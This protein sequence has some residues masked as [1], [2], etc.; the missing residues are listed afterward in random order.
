MFFDYKLECYLGLKLCASKIPF[1][2]KLQSRNKIYARIVVTGNIIVEA[3]EERNKNK[4]TGNLYSAVDVLVFNHSY[5]IAIV[6]YLYR[7]NVGQENKY[8]VT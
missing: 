4:L 8:S 2:I 7:V 1:S 3:V 6:S 5:Y